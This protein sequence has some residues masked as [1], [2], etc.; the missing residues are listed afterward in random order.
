MVTVIGILM[1]DLLVGI[2][3]GMAVA[4]FFLLLT[5]YATRTSWTTGRT[6]RVTPSA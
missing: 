1:T 6:S 3:L 2:G 5:N 4:V